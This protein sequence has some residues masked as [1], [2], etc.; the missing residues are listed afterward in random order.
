MFYINII[1]LNKNEQ[2]CES[3]DTEVQNNATRMFKVLI[4]NHAMYSFLLL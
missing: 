3:T 4:I 2:N 1:Y